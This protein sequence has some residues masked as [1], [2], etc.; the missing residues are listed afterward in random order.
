MNCVLHRT[1]GAAEE[2][3]EEEKERE[4]EAERQEEERAK[5]G[6]GKDRKIKFEMVACNLRTWETEAGG[7][8]SMRQE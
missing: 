6:G 1:K 4:K 5:G 3:E 7:L 2:E 8:T